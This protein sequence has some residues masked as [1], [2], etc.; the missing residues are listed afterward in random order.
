MGNAKSDVRFT[1]A[2]GTKNMFLFLTE[3]GISK[4]S[5]AVYGKKEFMSHFLLAG[6]AGIVGLVG[7]AC[8]Q[9]FSGEENKRSH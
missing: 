2:T 3:F 8:L 4:T 9:Y 6:W 5:L 1:K 7:N